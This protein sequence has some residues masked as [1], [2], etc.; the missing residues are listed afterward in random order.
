MKVLD[1]WTDSFQI[2]LAALFKNATLR[3]AVELTLQL[4]A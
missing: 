3:D 2:N 1:V 4:A